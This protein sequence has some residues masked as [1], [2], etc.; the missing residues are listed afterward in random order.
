MKISTHTGIT[1][2]LVVL[3]LTA[4][5][6]ATPPSSFYVLTPVSQTTE[7]PPPNS[8]KL[9]IGVGP[10]QVPEYLDRPQLVTRS[11]SNQLEL[12]EFDRWGGALNTNLLRVV[13]QNLSALTG[14]DN[15]VVYPWEDPVEPEFRIHLS[16]F[17][18]DGTL[19]GEVKLDVQWVIAS[20]DRRKNLASGHSVIHQITRGISYDE[21]VAAQSRA[22]AVLSRELADEILR[23]SGG[24]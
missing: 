24:G 19:G 23:L 1:V 10:V 13:A 2:H 16:I 7:S 22:L 14:S 5:C 18:F 6:A 21:F 3:L 4:G 15:V 11:T 9:T 17:S 8:E 20:K 12:S